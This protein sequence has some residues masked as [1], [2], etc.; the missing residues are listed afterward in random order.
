MI[1]RTEQEALAAKLSPSLRSFQERRFTAERCVKRE[2]K[3]I[4]TLPRWRHRAIEQAAAGCGIIGAGSAIAARMWAMMHFAKW[5][6]QIEVPQ[7]TTETLQQLAK[8]GRW[9][10]SLQRAM[11]SR[12]RLA[13][14]ITLSLYCARPVIR[15]AA[16]IKVFRRRKKPACADRRD[17]VCRR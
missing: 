8:N 4:M 10:R 1:L 5:R 7:A 13:S 15:S 9:W 12:N 3:S 17:P 16:S 6:S 11:P 2:P 14:A